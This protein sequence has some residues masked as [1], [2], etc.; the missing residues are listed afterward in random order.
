V[1]KLTALQKKG[2]LSDLKRMQ[3]TAVEGV[4]ASLMLGE[5]KPYVTAV[6]TTATGLVMR[7]ISYRDLGLK[8]DAAVRVS[9]DKVVTLDLKLEDS[10]ASTPED[11]IPIGTDEAGKPIPATEF[12]RASLTSK[13]DIPSGKAQAAEG[14][15]TNAKSDKAHTIVVVGVRV[16]EPDAKPEK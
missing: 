9:P 16:V 12:T 6:N 14:V 10:H 5:S 3:F 15:K 1:A 7:A 13:L 8:V 2:A 11:G 4:P